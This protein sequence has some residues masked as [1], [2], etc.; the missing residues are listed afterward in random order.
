ME[1]PE[2]KQGIT[3]VELL[4]QIEKSPNKSEVTIANR[5]YE[6]Y[7]AYFEVRHVIDNAVWRGIQWNRRDGNFAFT[8]TRDNLI[9]HGLSGRIVS[10]NKMLTTLQA[11]ISILAQE[12]EDDETESDSNF[13]FSDGEPASI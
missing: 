10:Y 9:I 7:G 13:N 12:D 1:E 5:E 4:R 8:C 11:N 3:G 6:L 2:E